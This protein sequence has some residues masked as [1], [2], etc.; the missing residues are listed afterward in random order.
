MVQQAVVLCGGLGSRLGAL[1]AKTP[2]PL[3]PVGGAPFLDVLLF[4]FGRH[5]IKRVLLL[6]GFAANCILDYVASTS[7][8]SRF[9]LEIDVSIEPQRAGTGGAL[10]HARDR[11]DDQ[12]LLLNGDSWFDIN[13]LDFACQAASDPSATGAIAV[14]PLPDASRY[15]V[16]EIDG[17]RVTRFRERPESAGSGLVSAGVY[18]FRRALVDDLAPCCSLEAGVLPVLADRRR[19]LGVPF[20]NYFIDIGVPHSFARA[21]H[22]VPARRRRAAVFFDRDGVLNHDDGYVGSW[23]RFRWVEGAKLAVKLLNDAGLFVFVV[24]NQAGVARGFYAENDVRTLH[25]QLQ[26]E[27]AASGAHFDDIRY[28]PFHPEAALPAYRRASDW[29]KPAPGMILDLLRCWPAD[30]ATSFLIGDRETD[31]A[32]AAAAGIESHLF[33]GGDLSLFVSNLLTT[34]HPRSRSDATA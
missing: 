9:D 18:F 4:E 23:D 21:Q 26:A 20:D 15:G 31:R 6:A 16:V 13:L 3:L 34:R 12:F 25:T 1:A 10:W 33:A 22:E 27:L 30:L 24:T 7:L 11:L 28:C 2:K 19:L 14:R 29:R 8:K 17:T 32:A 5:G